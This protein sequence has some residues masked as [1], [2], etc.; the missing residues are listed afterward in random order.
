M[1]VL[2]LMIPIGIAVFWLGYLIG[3]AVS[4]KEQVRELLELSD[5]YTKSLNKE[6]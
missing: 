3:K 2:Q 5:Y 4:E 1:T 6:K